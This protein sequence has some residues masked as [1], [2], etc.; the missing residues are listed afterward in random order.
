M[1]KIRGQIHLTKGR[2]S[3][4][5]FCLFKGIGGSR[6]GH[7]HKCFLLVEGLAMIQIKEV[8]LGN[9]SGDSDI[10]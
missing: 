10:R 3:Q 5:D 4:L 7:P 8:E 9:S 6:V 1:H 2:I